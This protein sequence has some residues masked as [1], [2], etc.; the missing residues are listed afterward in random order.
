MGNLE[1]PE[2]R[3]I[4]AVLFDLRMRYVEAAGAA[5]PAAHS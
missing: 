3:L 5:K 4:E 1:E 2:E